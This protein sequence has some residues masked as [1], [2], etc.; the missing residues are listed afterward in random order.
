MNPTPNIPH[1]GTTDGGIH[2]FSIC[3]GGQSDFS[4][5]SMPFYPNCLTNFNYSV[6]ASPTGIGGPDPVD[7]TLLS[8]TSRGPDHPFPN[9]QL[10]PFSNSDLMLSSIV[11]ANTR[12][13]GQSQSNPNRQRSSSSNHHLRRDSGA[14]TNMTMRSN[15]LACSRASYMCRK[16][17]T[18]GHNIPV[19]RH[20]RA[21]PYMHCTCLKCHLVDQGRKVV[22]K[23]IALYRD[24]KG[25]S[26]R[27]HNGSQAENSDPLRGDR[28]NFSTI[29]CNSSD[30]DRW[31]QATRT[32]DLTSF[33]D[34][35]LG[36]R[37]ANFERSLHLPRLAMSTT[38][39]IA[40]SQT[41]GQQPGLNIINTPSSNRTKTKPSPTATAG[42]HCRRCRNHSLA[43]T[44]KGHKKTCPFRNCPCDPC[45]LINVRKD[46][47]KTLREMVTHSGEKL[48]NL[49]KAPV[50]MDKLSDALSSYAD[51]P[52]VCSEAQQHPSRPELLHTTGALAGRLGELVPKPDRN[53]IGQLDT[54][55]TTNLSVLPARHENT[56]SPS[57]NM[58]EFNRMMKT[59]SGQVPLGPNSS[60]SRHIPSVW[61]NC[62]LER[63]SL[64]NTNWSLRSSHL[65]TNDLNNLSLPGR[66]SSM[67]WLLNPLAVNAK[68]EQN[69]FHHHH[70][71][72]VHINAPLASVRS[73]S[74]TY[75]QTRLLDHSIQPL[76][77][78][79]ETQP[80]EHS[81][82]PR[83]SSCSKLPTGSYLPTE[84]A[85]SGPGNMDT[86]VE[87]TGPYI[88]LNGTHAWSVGKMKSER[89]ARNQSSVWNNERKLMYPGLVSNTDGF[90]YYGY[91]SESNLDPGFYCPDRVS[92]VAAAA[93]AAAA[94][95][96]MAPPPL[97]S[98]SR[99]RC[100]QHCY[101]Y[102]YQTAQ[103]PGH[104][105]VDQISPDAYS[106]RAGQYVHSSRTH[107]YTSPSGETR[108]ARVEETMS[109]PMDQNHYAG[110]ASHSVDEYKPNLSEPNSL[111]SDIPKA[112]VSKQRWTAV[113][114]EEVP[115]QNCPAVQSIPNSP[116]PSA[117]VSYLE[118][119]KDAIE[120]ST[121]SFTQ[122]SGTIGAS[123][124]VPFSDV[125][126]ETMAE[127]RNHPEEREMFHTDFYIAN[128][129][130]QILM[131]RVS[132]LSPTQSHKP[133]FGD[134]DSM[135]V[136]GT[137]QTDN[138]EHIKYPTTDMRGKTLWNQ[139][140]AWPCDAVMDDSQ[141][142]TGSD[143]HE[144]HLSSLQT[145][146][147][148]N[149]SNSTK[150][151]FHNNVSTETF[152]N[153]RQGSRYTEPFDRLLPVL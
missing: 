61:S 140:K 71:H 27:E 28:P 141:T 35:S 68:L 136:Q 123:V 21:C 118:K 17:K 131:P 67:N 83:A 102:T 116:S 45:R 143:T 106:F 130:K 138:P 60:E 142:D 51:L 117:S 33:E 16:C 93:A 125:P 107:Q 55:L 84:F 64:N 26:S 82:E 38:L 90:G 129:S 57:A 144:Q 137:S 78:R 79:P 7:S 77:P 97:G 88:S 95:V 104:P 99:R 73:N 139:S 59:H 122:F 121:P 133:S 56:C 24:Q 22:A 114:G 39:A 69:H 4:F 63:I 62:G 105:L 100:P 135:P 145:N 111:A 149:S 70:H 20:K 74:P 3:N 124:H 14:L 92:A 66:E 103:D 150:I 54:D 108:A 76:F 151:E 53:P 153:N 148:Q 29:A 49:P 30:G 13:S 50:Q 58:K 146:R 86:R 40:T 96:A 120:S 109:Y 18:H 98:P 2:P 1:L 80:M 87:D 47:E 48:A 147:P 19:K 52:D 36:R 127:N 119:D 12:P 23:Q 65:Q 89:F 15:A 112:S 115:T 75:T 94:M 91:N 85:P 110:Y 31:V 134:A 44:W 10:E 152:R 6:P 42:P 101:Q 34:R 25:T 5:T 128:S 132:D 32:S 41:D 113:T 9:S 43:V 81:P 46:T 37:L 11:V 126:L 8:H 72:H